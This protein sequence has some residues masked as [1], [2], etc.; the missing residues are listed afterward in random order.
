MRHLTCWVVLLSLLLPASRAA[1]QAITPPDAEYWFNFASRLP[2]GST[3]SVRT[4]D[5]KRQ[6]AVLTLVDRDGITL[7][8][9]TRIPEAPRKVP[10]EQLAQLEPKHNGS[11]VA[12][13]AAIGVAAGAGTFFGIMMIMFSVV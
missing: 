6:T 8:P 7:Q 4:A 9:K 12:K 1:A 10:F 13:A 11:N 2:I 5:G 3:V